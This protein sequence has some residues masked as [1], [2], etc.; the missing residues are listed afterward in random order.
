MR[1]WEPYFLARHCN[2]TMS[3]QHPDI[4][5]DE[6]NEADLARVWPNHSPEPDDAYPSSN[7]ICLEEVLD[8]VTYQH[9][10]RLYSFL[11]T[12]VAELLTEGI[13]LNE[14]EANR[15]ALY[16]LL[17]EIF[18]EIKWI[19]NSSTVKIRLIRHQVVNFPYHF[20]HNSL[21]AFEEKKGQHLQP[22]YASFLY[23]FP[24]KALSALGCALALCMATLWRKTSSNMNT[25]DLAQH[26]NSALE[27]CKFD[28]RFSD[29]D[30]ITSFAD[31]KTSLNNK[32]IA[33]QGYVVKA[34]P[35]R[36][37]VTKADFRCN[38]CGEQFPFKLIGGRY[39]IP[40]RCI[41]SSCKSRNFV[42]VRST[43]KYIGYQEL[44][45]Q[46]TPE[47]MVAGAYSSQSHSSRSPRQIEVHVMN[48]LVDSCVT[49]DIIKVTGIVNSISTALAAGRSG[50]QALETSTYKLYIKANSMGNT[51]SS[52][53]NDSQAPGND[54]RG[55]SASAKIS[56]TDS[57]LQSIRKIAQADHKIGSM[58]MR[59]AFPFDLL[60]HSLCPSIVGHELVKAGLLL[61]LLGGTP[62]LVSGTDLPLGSGIRSNSHV[63]IVG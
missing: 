14:P 26:L 7:S 25:T 46:E 19:G 55:K 53:P 57:Q 13:T 23:H 9:C 30:R 31:I 48:D 47:E 56:F 28:V 51:I 34:K 33:I 15:K 27:Q 54:R 32:F 18:C 61:T 41:S 40:T 20:F 2:D 5:S 36:L 8:D 4:P 50:R 11:L 42:I 16:H 3:S 44:K 29:A 21:R 38:R 12:T 52:E 6:L 45:L 43:A 10:R 62:S 35:K 49:G 37:R 17:L 58:K 63:L 39:N 59:Q 22:S 24:G 60:V 1:G